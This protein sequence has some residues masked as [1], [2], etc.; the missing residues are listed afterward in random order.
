M[1]FPTDWPG[2]EVPAPL[3]VTDSPA[4]QASFIAEAASSSVSTVHA[5]FGLI[6]IIPASTESSR[7]ASS[8][9]TFRTGRGR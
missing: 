1:P 4:F 8:A 2:M 3:G 9:A 6:S 5:P 7:R